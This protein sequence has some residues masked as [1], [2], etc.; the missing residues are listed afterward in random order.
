MK[1]VFIIL[2]LAVA[3]P[4]FCL[5]QNST[6]SGTVVSFQKFPMPGVVVKAKKS[7]QEV[8]TSELGE[9]NIEVGKRDV[10]EFIADGFEKEKI[11]AAELKDLE[12]VNMIFVDKGKNRAI[13]VQRG[14]L[15]KENLSYAVDHLIFDNNRASRY[16]NIYEMVT[17]SV[18]GIQMINEGGS[19]Q[20]MIRGPKSLTLSNAA[21][22]VVNGVVTNDISYISP[23]EVKSIDI[24]RGPQASMFGGRG[25][26]GV[27]S[28]KLK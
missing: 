23:L 12:E 16:N 21:L 3:A 2:A 14:Y 13:A 6:I 17:N 24:L 1:K 28:I 25:A 10:V 4:L 18:P 7:G 27:I 5:A 11:K 9:F 15:S 19:P 8:Q 26:N 22:L 20:F